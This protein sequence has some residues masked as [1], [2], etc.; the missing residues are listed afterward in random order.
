MANVFDV[1]KYIL[2]E[3]GEMTAMKLQK[4]VF[5][6]QTRSLMWDEQ[7]MFDE[8]IEAR[9]NGPVVPSLYEQHK[10]KFR[11]SASDVSGSLRHPFSKQ[12]KT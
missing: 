10:G 6:S 11:V 9:A 4:L 7:P 12:K 5:Y 1:A 8:R 3:E 2:T